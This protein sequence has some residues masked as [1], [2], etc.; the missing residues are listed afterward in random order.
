MNVDIGTGHAI[1]RKG[2]HK[3]DF[4]CSVLVLIVRNK[5]TVQWT[6]QLAVRILYISCHCIAWFNLA[7]EWTQG[8]SDKCIYWVHVQDLHDRLHEY[9]VYLR[10]TKRI[11]LVQCVAR[12]NLC[13][14]TFTWHYYNLLFVACRKPHFARL[15]IISAS[16]R[17][18]N[19][20]LL[21]LWDAGTCTCETYGIFCTCTWLL[22]GYPEPE[23]V[24]LL[25]KKFNQVGFAFKMQFNPWFAR[26]KD[27]SKGAYIL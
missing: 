14:S 5:R 11:F 23:R 18:A 12:R 26:R 17:V 15:I 1:P 20:S 10:G 19:L 6:H 2:I 16:V 24:S 4:R 25:D 27:E 9:T 7:R 21:Y 13:F 22:L 3:W 8:R